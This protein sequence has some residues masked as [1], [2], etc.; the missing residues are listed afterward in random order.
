[1]R[2]LM[3][4]MMLAQAAD[5]PGP[6]ATPTGWMPATSRAEALAKEG[7]TLEAA[8]VYEQYSAKVP[9]FPASHYL[10]VELLLKGGRRDLVPAA[11]AR[12]R[13]GIPPDA[14][15]RAEAAMFLKS[16]A[17]GSGVSRQDA[18]LLLDDARAML[19]A[20][21][22]V[23]PGSRDVLTQKASV[24]EAWAE[25]VETSAARRKALQAE[26]DALR[27]RAYGLRP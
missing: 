15:M 26:A 4:L 19:D 17:S 6:M 16:V 7:K 1:M 23:D 20:V 22:K 25:H 5:V 14:A 11:L 12:A 27:E 3:T 9:W 13:Q 18:R 10:R 21:L 24:L 8:E 2:L